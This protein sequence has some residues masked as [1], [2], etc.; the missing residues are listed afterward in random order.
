MSSPKEI[1]LKFNRV[2]YAD[3][4]MSRPVY[5]YYANIFLLMI[6]LS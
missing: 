5:Y 3:I 4:N 1:L 6:A 2:E